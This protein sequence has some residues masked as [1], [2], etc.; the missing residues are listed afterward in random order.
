MRRPVSIVIVVLLQWAAAVLGLI[1]AFDLIA[2]AIEMSRSGVSEQIESTLVA[3]NLSETSGSLVVAGVG[4]AGVMVGM[5]AL[6]RILVAG[7]LWQGRSW[8]RLVLALLIV[9]NVIGSVGQLIEGYWLRAGALILLDL[10]MLWLM[11]TLQS[12]QFVKARGQER[13]A[14]ARAVEAA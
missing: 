3:Q 14:Q 6:L 7:Y 8:A 10:V 13:K 2:F 12:S 9:L 5:L 1:A 4:M 11:F